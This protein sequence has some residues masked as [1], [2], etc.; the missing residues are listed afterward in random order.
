MGEV[1]V[2]S[3]GIDKERIRRDVAGAGEDGAVVVVVVEGAEAGVLDGR[4]PEDVVL[5]QVGGGP[6]LQCPP[7]DGAGKRVVAE[8]VA[9]TSGGR[10]TVIVD[11][12]DQVVLHQPIGGGPTEVDGEEIEVACSG[13]LASAADLPNDF[14]PADLLKAADDA[15]YRAKHQGRNQV[16]TGKIIKAQAA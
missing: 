9:T 1:V 6:A 16:V 10:G 15:L 2:S 3:G 14:E 11:V 8:G 4:R 5:E 13:G 7:N 12:V